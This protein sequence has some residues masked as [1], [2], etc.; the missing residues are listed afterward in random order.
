MTSFARSA[1]PP[2]TDDSALSA[3]LQTTDMIRDARD[4]AW[5][6]MLERAQ[7]LVARHPEFA[8]GHSVLASAYAEAADSIDVPDRARAMN[9]AA[10]R[11]ANLTL[12]LDPEDAGAYAILS[13]LEPRYDYR[14]REAI[15]LRGIK[16][17]K[18]PKGAAWR[19]VFL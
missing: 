13:E 5:A 3:L 8:F 6:P 2:L 19:I 12:K 16:I 17:R 7:G 14:A 11:E 1:N 4:G 9:D 18:T 10:R 15:L